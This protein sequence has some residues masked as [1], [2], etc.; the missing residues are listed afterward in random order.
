MTISGRCLCKEV[1]FKCDEIGTAG[2]CHCEDCRRCTGSAFN[3]SVR[4]ATSAFHILSG[5]LGSFTKIGSSGFELTRSFCKSCGSQ[6]FVSSPL[7]TSIVYIKAGV[8]DDPGMVRPNL[9]AWVSFKVDWA[10]IPAGLA[11]FEKS[12]RGAT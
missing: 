1:T 10:T 3:I 12:R 9:E 5:E 6:I 2:Y 7:D 8:L 4:C 11:T